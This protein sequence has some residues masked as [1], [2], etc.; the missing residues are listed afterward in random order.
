MVCDHMASSSRPKIGTTVG[1]LV[2]CFRNL[3]YALQ[4]P[5]APQNQHSQKQLDRNQQQLNGN[6]RRRDGRLGTFVWCSLGDTHVTA[7]LCLMSWVHP[8]LPPSFTVHFLGQ[9]S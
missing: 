7:R 6:P 5:R 4:V 9:V 1:Y 2:L 8:L 3:Q